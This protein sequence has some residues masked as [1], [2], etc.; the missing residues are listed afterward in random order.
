ML[1]PIRL[2]T[3]GVALSACGGA[4]GADDDGGGPPPG[5]MAATPRGERVD[6]AWFDRPDGC[7]QQLLTH[8][9]ECRPTPAEG[10]PI[11]DQPEAFGTLD[12]SLR[13]CAYPN[14][15]RVALRDPLPDIY[16]LDEFGQLEAFGDY[17]YRYTLS[18][19]AGAE[20]LRFD[21]DEKPFTLHL[22]SGDFRFQ[23]GNLTD[24]DAAFAQITCPDGREVWL[25]FAETSKCAP[26]AIGGSLGSYHLH[27]LVLGFNDDQIRPWICYAP[28]P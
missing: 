16:G 27:G 24:L 12:A 5:G 20:C 15:A 3:L 10:V 28:P 4:S 21:G 22:P 2:L 17:V 18:D 8:V 11:D 25:P 1:T 19:A 23:Y 9:G 14:G 7:W 13:T 26:S 6:C